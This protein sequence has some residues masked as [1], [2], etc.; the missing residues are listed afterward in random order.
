[1]DLTL[2]GQEINNATINC[3]RPASC[4]FWTATLLEPCLPLVLFSRVRNSVLFLY[5]STCIS[6]H[7]V[8]NVSPHA[9]SH[10]ILSIV[11]PFLYFEIRMIINIFGLFISFLLYST[12]MKITPRVLLLHRYNMATVSQNRFCVSTFPPYLCR[13]LNSNDTNSFLNTC[14]DVHVLIAYFEHIVCYIKISWV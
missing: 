7:H 2:E 4:H 6:M 10:S 9:H 13:N 11:T 3:V 5:R 14:I 12:H 1:M 8:F